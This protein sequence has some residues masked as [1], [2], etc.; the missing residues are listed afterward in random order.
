[1]KKALALPLFL[2]MTAVGFAQQVKHVVLIT[3]DGFRPDFY[4]DKS[5]NTTNLHQLMNSGVH[6][7]G[8]NSVL[9]SVTYPSHT[10]IITGVWPEQHGVYYNGVFEPNGSTGKIYW[11]DSSIKVPTIWSAAQKKGL[12]V[13]SLFWPVSANAPV[14]YNIPDIGSM[15]EKVRAEYSRPEGFIDTLKKHVFNDSSRIEYGK[16]HNV[17]NIAAYVIKKDQP[18]LM[19][20][21]FFSVD[22]YQHE[23]GRKGDAVTAAIRDADS[24]VGI[25]V[26][27]LKAAKIWEQTLLIVTGDHGFKDV[28]TNVHPNVW[29][30]KAGLLND[31]KNGDWKAQFNTAGGTTFLYLKDKKDI[32]TLMKVKDI[33]KNLSEEEK[34]YIRIIERKKINEVGGNPEVALVLTGENGASFGNAATGEAIRTGKGGTHGYFPDFYEIRTGFVA[35]GPGIKGGSV[36]NDMN[37]RDITPYISKVLGLNLTSTKGKIPAALNK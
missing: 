34:K 33:L 30:A 26:N 13:A 14:M 29:L 7:K 27:A 15:G 36:I 37:L 32:S 9:P 25:I 22:H 3:I 5:W 21:H 35:S 1:M 2:L 17:A 18:N 16:D 4:L 31:A 10:T 23:Q 6:A 28:N 24:S 11:N 8:V 20:I 12:K 19:T